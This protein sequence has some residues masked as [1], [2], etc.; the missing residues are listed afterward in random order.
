MAGKKQVKQTIGFNGWS[1]PNFTTIVKT[2]KNFTSNFNGAMLYAHYELSTIELKKEVVKYLKSID[3]KHPYLERIKD[4]HEN[5]LSIVGKYMYIINHGGDIPEKIAPTLMPA[6]EKII[7]E[8][9]EKVKKEKEEAEYFSKITGSETLGDPNKNVITIQDR[10]RDKAK[11]IC[12]EVE[13]WLDDLVIDKKTQIKTV[14]EFVALFKSNDLKGPHM[15]FIQQAFSRRAEHALIIAEGKDKSLLEGYSNF[16]KPE[17]KKISQFYQ[18]L[19]SATEMLQEAAKVER[20]PRKKKPMS[21]EKM[22]SKLKFKKDDPT[23]GIVSL[24]PV[25]II[26]AKEVWLY[27]TKL[28]KLSQYKSL[29][30]RGILVKGSSLENFSSEST[31]KTLRK[32]AETLAEFKKASKIKLRTFL[33]DLTT[34]DIPANGKVNENHVI[35]RIDR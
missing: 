26:G 18:N 22:V 3:T 8:E 6:L 25:Q 24:N 34:V 10:L 33:K 15:K 23:L 19:I 29:D 1:K 2:N 30:D 32:P 5:R 13:G 12:G 14:D 16:T 21:Q 9:E 7:G 28:R 4:I 20:A 35:L 11:E 17:L 27:N 31:E